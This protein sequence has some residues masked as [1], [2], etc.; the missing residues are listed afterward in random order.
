MQD[1]VDHVLPVTEQARRN[2]ANL[3]PSPF[4][5]GA[6]QVLTGIFLGGSL[7]NILAMAQA[8][9]TFPVLGTLVSLGVGLIGTFLV[10]VHIVKD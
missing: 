2:L 10:A 5:T 7:S 8:G 6:F 3:D 4:T 1:G 9:N